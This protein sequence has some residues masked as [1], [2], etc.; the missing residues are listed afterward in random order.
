MRPIPPLKKHPAGKPAPRASAR[1]GASAGL[2][3]LDNLQR[4]RTHRDVVHHTSR[5]SP[6]S[7]RVAA[8]RASEGV[9]ACGESLRSRQQQ[10]LERR[11]LF[12]GGGREEAEQR[13][14]G[15][16]S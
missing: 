13:R 6:A 9:Q 2:S 5:D 7:T 15:G 4:P 1:T 10:V 8:F 14:G 12:L 3:Q 11:P 16:G